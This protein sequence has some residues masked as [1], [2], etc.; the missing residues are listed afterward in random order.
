MEDYWPFILLLPVKPTAQSKILAS[1]FSSEIAL[2]VL[3]LLKIEGKTYQKDIVKKLSYHSNKSVLN[4]LKRFVEVGIV[5]EGIEQASVEGRKVWIKWYK[6]TVIGKWLIL[7][8]TSRRDLSS[9]DIKFLLRELIGYYA[10]SIARLC[11]E[12]G[13]NPLYF[14]EIF[15]K[16][17][18]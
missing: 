10:K 6:P 16:S 14:R 8:L 2:K 12:Y 4:H 13:L 15:D 1:V 9:A 5:K 11:K 7:L 3:N 18:E 17:L